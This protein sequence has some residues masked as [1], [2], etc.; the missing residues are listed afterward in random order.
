MQCET[1]EYSHEDFATGVEEIDIVAADDAYAVEYNMGSGTGNYNQFEKVYQ[2]NSLE[3]ATATGIVSS[4]YYPTKTLKVTNIMG[5]FV[6]AEDIIGVDSGAQYTLSSYD[7]MKD[8]QIED[9]F[10]N[11]FI[12]NEANNIMDFSET[13][14]FGNL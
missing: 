1:F 7:D 9:A 3:E 11:R 4:W 12:E 6:N 14:P 8:S 5:T 2:G 13:N 10:D